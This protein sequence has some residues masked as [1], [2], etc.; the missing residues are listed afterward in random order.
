MSEPVKTTQPSLTAHPA[1][2]VLQMHFQKVRPL[3]LRQ[4]FAV[5]FLHD[6]SW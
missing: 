2:K 6:I 1:W 3:H 5:I 4:L